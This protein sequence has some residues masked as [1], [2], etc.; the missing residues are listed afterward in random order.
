MSI[1]IRDMA[2][3]TSCSEC[4]FEHMAMHYCNVIKQST[5]HYSTGKK[6]QTPKHKDCPLVEI[7]LP[8]NDNNE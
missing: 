6:I 2:M 8:E 4:P 5:S 7:S 1:L 3:P